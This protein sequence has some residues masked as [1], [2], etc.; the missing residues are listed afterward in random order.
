MSEQRRL[1]FVESFDEDGACMPVARW[2]LRESTTL[3]G[4]RV[5]LPAAVAVA[6]FPGWKESLHKGYVRWAAAVC[7]P[8]GTFLADFAHWRV[9]GQDVRRYECEG[10]ADSSA[11]WTM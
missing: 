7:A 8:R 5:A 11:W 4:L 3:G 10:T 6:P 2:W 1:Q 9:W